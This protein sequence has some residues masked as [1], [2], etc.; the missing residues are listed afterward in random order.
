MPEGWIMQEVDG[1]A[2][3]LAYTR[4]TLKTRRATKPRRSKS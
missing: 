4:P 2:H 3:C 1:G